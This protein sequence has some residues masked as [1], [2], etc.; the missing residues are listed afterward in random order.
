MTWQSLDDL[1]TLAQELQEA[2]LSLLQDCQTMRRQ[3]PTAMKHIVDCSA[4]QE[5]GNM[6]QMTRKWHEEIGR[7]LGGRDLHDIADRDCLENIVG[8]QQKIVALQQENVERI[9][10]LLVSRQ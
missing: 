10:T 5:I 8:L 1:R 6:L 9:R 4:R 7:L 3:H 2:E